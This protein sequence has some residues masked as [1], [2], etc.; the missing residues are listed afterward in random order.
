MAIESTERRVRIS[1][2]AAH[3]NRPSTPKMQKSISLIGQKRGRDQVDDSP[4]TKIVPP[5]RT[6]SVGDV[7]RLSDTERRGLVDDVYKRGMIKEF[8]KDALSGVVQAS[9]LCGLLVVFVECSLLTLRMIR[10]IYRATILPT[11]NSS[12]ISN[13][14]PR[15]PS[16]TYPHSS[17]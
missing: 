4:A 11:S 1:P 8:V 5:R 15:R 16:R 17:P 12:L 9:H 10:E 6:K 7:N 13:L 14:P 3:N 2:D